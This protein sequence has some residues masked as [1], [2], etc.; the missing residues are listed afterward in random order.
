MAK[1]VVG[2]S[3]GRINGNCE[4]LL[5]EA[6]MVVEEEGF[7]TEIIRAMELRVKPCKGCETC[8]MLMAQGKEP[9]CAITDDDVP[10]ILERILLTDD[11]FILAF[12]VYHLRANGYLECIH[13][14]MLPLV[15]GRPEI[16]EKN[17]VAGIISV[18]GGEPEWT[19]LALTSANIFVQHC[20]RVVDQMQVNFCGRPGKV[21]LHPEYMERA[22]LLGKRVAQAM[23]MPLEQ[24]TYQG[25]TKATECPVCHCDVLKAPTEKA[26]VYCP[27]CWTRGEVKIEDGRLRIDWDPETVKVPR[28]SPQGVATHV[29]FIKKLQKDYYDNIDKVKEG[30]KKYKDW[31][32]VLKP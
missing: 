20:W 7:E 19:T 1:K 14:R 29:E 27:V 18:G 22:R 8:T 3:C 26:E 32:K 2:L 5:K 4:I 9:K 15:F 30:I 31:G 25:E 16:L 21:L 12:P 13:E 10:W 23:K 11:G 24:V 6:L 28:F 17:K